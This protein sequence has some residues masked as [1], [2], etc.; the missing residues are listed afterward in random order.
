MVLD[1]NERLFG[2]GA[3]MT[4]GCDNFYWQPPPTLM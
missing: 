3:I 2:H 1:V 4:T